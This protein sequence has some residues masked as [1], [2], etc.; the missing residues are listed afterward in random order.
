MTDTHALLPASLAIGVIDRPSLC[1]EP[2][3][4][5]VPWAVPCDVGAS[6]AP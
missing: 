3:Q 6:E 1:R 4:R 2:D 5:G